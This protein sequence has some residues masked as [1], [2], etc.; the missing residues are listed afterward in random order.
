MRSWNGGY[1]RG[2][3]GVNPLSS[4]S[5]AAAWFPALNAVSTAAMMVVAMDCVMTIFGSTANDAALNAYITDT[6]T[7]TVRG[8]VESVL[9][10]LPLI[11]MLIIFGG[12]DAMTKQGH[13]SR[14]FGIFGALV[15]LTGLAGIFLLKDSRVPAPK[16]RDR[17]SGMVV[18]RALS[19]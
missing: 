12:F 14:F 7:E 8:Q 13:W 17:Y 19:R 3:A 16:R 15:T 5:R 6:T 18:I 11:S 1:G 2:A 9:A 10:V 4:V